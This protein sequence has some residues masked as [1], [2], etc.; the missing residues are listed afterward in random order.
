MFYWELGKR[1]NDEYGKPH[2][3]SED[4]ACENR[5]KKG[6]FG[7]SKLNDSYASLVKR[8]RELGIKIT[9]FDLRQKTSKGLIQPC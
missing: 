6:K 1:V 3:K 9:A 2:A 7:A 4:L 5:M 8:L